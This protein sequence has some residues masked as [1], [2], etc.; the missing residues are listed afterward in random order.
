MRR[1]QYEGDPDF[2]V[3]PGTTDRMHEDFGYVVE[4]DFNPDFV[5]GYGENSYHEGFKNGLAFAGLASAA[6]G[7][8]YGGIKLIRKKIRDRKNKKTKSEKEEPSE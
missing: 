2:W 3:I 4:Q 5:L 6:A 7:A 8:I 1:K